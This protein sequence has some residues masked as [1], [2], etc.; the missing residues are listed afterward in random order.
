MHRQGATSRLQWRFLRGLLSVSWRTGR[1]WRPSTAL[2]ALAAA[3]GRGTHLAGGGAIPGP[4]PAKHHLKL[5]PGPFERGAGC[6]AFDEDTPVE[7]RLEPVHRHDRDG[8][9]LP[10]PSIGR[11]RPPG[12]NLPDM[13]PSPGGRTGP[14]PPVEETRT[15][16]E[17]IVGTKASGNST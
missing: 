10:P 2:S 1:L 11:Q 12:Q 9:F 5:G 6:F 3:G 13:Q 17:L 8:Q 7:R 15:S 14:L 4:A 16:L